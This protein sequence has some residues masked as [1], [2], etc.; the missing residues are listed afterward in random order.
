MLA[1]F[2][3]DKALF[4]DPNLLGDLLGE[5]GLLMTAKI[6]LGDPTRSFFSVGEFK[7]ALDD[8]ALLGG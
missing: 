4:G 6:L 7:A 3:F 8:L 1:S 5:R 2:V